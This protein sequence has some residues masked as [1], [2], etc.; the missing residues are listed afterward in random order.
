MLSLAAVSRP[1]SPAHLATVAASTMP[2]LPRAM[3][4]DMSSRKRCFASTALKPVPPSS[5][6]RAR[7]FLKYGST[8]ALRNSA[9]LVRGHG[10]LA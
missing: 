3:L 2:A 8:Q 10:E 7:A 4:S 1:P 5:I 9:V 6:S